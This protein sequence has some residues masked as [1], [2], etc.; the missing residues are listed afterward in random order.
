MTDTDSQR[1][2]IRAYL[3]QGGQLTSIDALNRFRCF[4]L[5]SRISELRLKENH[6]NRHR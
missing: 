2:Q 1:A 3:M 5:A 6:R 4:R